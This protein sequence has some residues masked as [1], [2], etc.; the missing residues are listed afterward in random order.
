V[1]VTPFMRWYG[2]GPLFSYR[3]L[4]HGCE[5][6]FHFLYTCN[7]SLKREFLVSVG[8]FDE[9]FKMA[10]YEDTELGFR[11]SEAGLR[12]LYNARA[13]G[14]HYQ[15]FTFADACRKKRRVE[16]ARQLFLQTEAGQRALELQRSRDLRLSFK[17]A[18]QIAVCCA[19]AFQPLVKL[20]DS[21]LPLPGIVYR[22]LFWYHAGRPDS[23]PR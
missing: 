15:H 17:V 11:L 2:E 6:H 20:L 10:A 4:Q 8:G 22:T 19:G 7:V 9:R 5:A 23:S 18:K 14:Y 12:L 21:R 13:I 3:K 16:S 1:R